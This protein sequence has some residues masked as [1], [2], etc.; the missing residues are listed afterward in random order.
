MSAVSAPAA[1]RSGPSG[2]PASGGQRMKSKRVQAVVL[3][4]AVAVGYAGAAV[5]SA[6]G[7]PSVAVA[8]GYGPGD[9][10]TRFVLTADSGD[11]SPDLLSA[12][13]SVD[14]VVS[15]QRLSDGR[16]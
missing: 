5:Y 7:M 14:G 4:A 10:L 6:W 8:D 12:L 13:R 11:A 1:G 3:A 2:G 16:A 15:A 9:G